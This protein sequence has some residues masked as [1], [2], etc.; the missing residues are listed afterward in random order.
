MLDLTQLPQL[1]ALCM[2]DAAVSS[3][4]MLLLAGLVGRLRHL[5]AGKIDAVV[6]KT[7]VLSITSLKLVGGISLKFMP[8]ST[9]ISASDRSSTSAPVK[10]MAVLM[11]ALQEL[12]R[13]ACQTI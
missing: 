9:T 7:A 5:H 8:Q 2:P 1:D 10:A 6:P 3:K 11:P 12:V 4:V 13:T